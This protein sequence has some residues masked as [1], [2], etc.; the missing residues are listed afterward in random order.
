M[1]QDL[2]IALDKWTRVKKG[3][4]DIVCSD[5]D[6]DLLSDYFKDKDTSEAHLYF[7][8]TCSPKNPD[9]IG[10]RDTYLL[11]LSESGKKLLTQYDL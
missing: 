4:N 7:R 3:G 11:Q 9:A 2:N 8:Y 1:S 10:T 6:L 5:R